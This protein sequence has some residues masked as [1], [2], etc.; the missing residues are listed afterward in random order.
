MGLGRTQPGEGPPRS[1]HFPMSQSSL[2]FL[3]Q[4]EVT[5][6][7][8][9]VTDFYS[10]K[11]RA[12]LAYLALEPRTHTRA[13]VAALLWPKTADKHAHTNLRST[14]YRLRQTLDAA[15]AGTADQ[16]LDVSRQTVQ[17]KAE[18]AFIDV[19]RF[20]MLLNDEDAATNN[21][22][23]RLDEALGLYQGELLMGFSVADA[24][25]FEEWLLLRRELLQQRALL[26]FRV[27]ATEHEAVGDFDHAYAV[28]RRLLAL[29]AY[30]EEDYRRMMRLLARMG[31]SQ[32]ALGYFEGMRQRVQDELG[33]D[34]SAETLALAKEIT[35][36]AFD[37][38][39]GTFGQGVAGI[40]Q[41]PSLPTTPIIDS[42]SLALRDV[43]NSGS[44][45]GRDQ[46]RQQLTRWLVQDRS[47]IVG[48]LGIGGMGKTSLAAQCVR[49]LGA[50]G[51]GIFDCILW[52]SLLNAPPLEELL[53][54]IL[55]I[56]SN[57][58]LAEIPE[59]MDEQLRL[60][61]NY[62]QDKRVLLVLDNMES[63]LE[64]ERAGIYRAGY[65]AYS[66]LI[67]MMAT[68]DH[69]SQLLFTSRE[70]PQGYERLIRDSLSIQS[71]QLGGLDDEAGHKLLAQRGLQAGADEES[72]LIERYSGNPLALKL[73]ADTIDEVFGGDL[74]GFLAEDTLIF[75]D[76]RTVLD[77]HFA[78][79][80]NIEQQI[81]FCLTVERQPVSA[82]D[83]R[84][85]LLQPPK[86]G[87]F[88]E[89]LR[90]LRRRSLVERQEDG[91][92]LQN[93]VTE[94]LTERLVDEICREIMTGDFHWMHLQALLKAQ[95]KEAVRQFQ[96]RLI[97]Q[98]VARQ[99]VSSLGLEKLK[100]TLNQ[101]LQRLRDE[102]PI[103]QS[104]A[105][106][107]VFNL[108]AHLQVDLTEFDFS[109]LVVWQANLQGL[110]LANVNFARANLTGSAF[111]Q[112]FGQV[113]AVAISPNGQLLAAGSQSGDITL[114]RLSDCQAVRILTGHSNIVS[115]LAFSPDGRHLASSSID[116][117]IRLWDVE[118]GQNVWE[119]AGDQQLVFSVAF[120]PDGRFLASGGNDPYV[121][122]WDRRSAKLICRLDAHPGGAT[123][124]V[125]FHPNGALLGAA[126]M[127]GAIILW[128]VS[129]L[130]SEDATSKPSADTQVEV[131]RHVIPAVDEE[132]FIALSFSPDGKWF[133]SGDN[134]GKIKVWDVQRRK[135]V[136]T[137]RGHESSVRSVEFGLTNATLVSSSFDHTVRLW[138]VDGERCDAVF[139]HDGVVWTA[140]FS[141][142]GKKLVSSGEDS[143]VRIWETAPQR[144]AELVKMIQGYRCYIPAAAF[145]PS[146]PLLVLGDTLGTIRFWDIR[147]P[148][149]H[150]S[151]TI[152]GHD[153]VDALAFRPG[154]RY[155]ASAGGVHDH[156]IRIWD[157]TTQQCVA[158]LTGHVRQ[159]R[160][161][162]FT[163]DGDILASA[164]TD[165]TIRLWNVRNPRACRIHSVL[166]G[167]QYAI[168]SLSFSADGT[169]LAS[170]SQDSTIRIWET[171]TGRQIHCLTG[172]G[173]NE[174]VAFSPAGDLLACS[175]GTDGSIRLLDL[176]VPQ[177][178]TQL[179]TLSG[180]VHEPV[181]I[182]FSPDGKRL[183]SSSS[184]QSIRL[185]DIQR[186][187]E[188]AVFKAHESYV[189]FVKFSP[190]GRHFLSCSI[191]GIAHLWDAETGECI[192]SFLA[193][194]PYDAMNITG[195]VGISEAQRFALKA[196]GAVE[197]VEVRDRSR[198]WLQ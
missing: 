100:T 41:A 194:R 178:E 17:F 127:G 53:P 150:Y 130:Y 10:N 31:Q 3:G 110:L 2:N 139:L 128:D 67:Q 175:A 198:Q 89:A 82:Q 81:L 125:A 154:G 162:A 197:D 12:L 171:A 45:L 63:I 4:F 119:I 60:L 144:R 91:L 153:W 107:N 27:L 138:D 76:I 132:R 172:L 111:T 124:D 75:D 64:P 26:A 47:K 57:Q 52:R 176:S 14:L 85:N 135:I 113:P 120:S 106:G 142:D 180:H 187:K 48:I 131:T 195:V 55:Q 116:A 136:R 40:A 161:L 105:G 166:H 167:H 104:Y 112:M 35:G 34:L 56:L 140:T 174:I 33:V 88:L 78:R 146:E 196:L 39:I 66:Y 19:H 99:L 50:S 156:A 84:Q 114:W 155:L 98:P 92:M 109:R 183:V 86:Q 73:V 186:G 134:L 148:E 137:L 46:E 20:Q 70:R 160:S 193:P 141:P 74:G 145:S 5:I 121:H 32:Q 30:H 71:L 16:M 129:R 102:T 6:G 37:K 101:Q 181:S 68:L 62:L 11:A 159:V 80:S 191:D 54:P 118:L 23:E 143:I 177:P 192:H 59:S 108:L 90:N 36:G 8:A 72:M 184:D 158:I 13:A 147:Q 77:Q 173:G 25:A 152:Q 95:A 163:P 15:A 168:Y 21:R 24:P 185:W 170:S 151:Y 93:V 115:E 117:T 96:I 87:V 51:R 7:S 58:Q 157:I 179:R 38:V 61:F 43:P 103:R 65:V 149:P 188:V 122:L 69:Q 189:N 28:T 182:S 22:S 49:E 18:S 79:L 29:D 94:Y 42:S 83:L 169:K 190:T 133:A 165:S 164:G 1:Q 44:F 9:R 97:V 126:N 123:R